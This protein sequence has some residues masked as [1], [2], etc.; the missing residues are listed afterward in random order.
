MHSQQTANEIVEQE[1]RLVQ[2]LAELSDRSS[3]ILN[4]TGW[5]SRVYIV[6]YG[7]LVFK[8]P[9]SNFVKKQYMN[10]AAIFRLL[11][12]IH[13]DILI[14]K[15]RWTHP[16]NDYFGYEGIVGTAFDQIAKDT[17]SRVKETLGQK[18]GE[19]LKQL[20]G[21]RLADARVMTSEGEIEEFQNK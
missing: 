2:K 6:N 11:G 21:L 15:A 18:L 17:D 3:I 1:K 16:Q 7:Q 5:D 20:H 8:F 9:R 13:S 19:F 4:D 10:E 12:P 14:P